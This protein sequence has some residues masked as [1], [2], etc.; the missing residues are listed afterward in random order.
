MPLLKTLLFSYLRHALT[1]AAGYLLAHGLVDQA[2][3]QI[4]LSAGLAIA[5]VAW[6]TAQ[7][8][9]AQLELQLAAK[10]LPAT[11]AK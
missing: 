11:P 7:K 5:G 8:F 4:L 1:L 9:A 3:G 2:G 10:T 6:S